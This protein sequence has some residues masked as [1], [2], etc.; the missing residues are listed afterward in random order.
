MSSHKTEPFFY[1]EE[2]NASISTR[3]QPT[4]E[5]WKS[6]AL[7]FGGFVAYTILVSLASMYISHGG[8]NE[9]QAAIWGMPNP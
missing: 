6:F 1:E 2:I 7:K 8:L 5:F 4:R 9:G 3:I